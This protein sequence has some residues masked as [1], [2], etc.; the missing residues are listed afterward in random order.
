MITLL[1]LETLA[2]IGLGLALRFY[3]P[4]N[5]LLTTIQQKPYLRIVIRHSKGEE[6]GIAKINADFNHQFLWDLDRYY[7][8]LG[9]TDYDPT[10]PD[11]VKIALFMD[12]VTADVAEQYRP[13]LPPEMGEDIGDGVPV[14]PLFGGPE[15]KT[16]VDLADK[17]HKTTGAT[18]ETG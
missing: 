5:K 8:A 12:D 17:I 11:H 2:L 6:D 3:D 18:L 15:A 9:D 14:M 4:V 1:V 10:M 16:V 7:S 13:N